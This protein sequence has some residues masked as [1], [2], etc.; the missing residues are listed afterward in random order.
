M[1]PGELDRPHLTAHFRL[2]I[3]GLPLVSFSECSGLGGEVGVE[4]YLEG[5][6]NRFAHR[7]PTRGSSPNL[8]LSRGV[9][10][11]NALW[12]WY[13]EYL[14]SGRVVPRDGQVELLSLIDG[15][16]SPVRVWWFRRGYPVKVAGPELNASSSE[17]AIETLEIAHHGLGLV[18]LAAV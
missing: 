17:V 4:E 11:S 5:G 12:L 7:L 10:S 1:P 6:E 16:L 9:A 14:V 15:E 13:A 18:P 8:V 3:T 2:A